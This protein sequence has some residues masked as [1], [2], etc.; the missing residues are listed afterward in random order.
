MATSLV[1]D[2]PYVQGVSAKNELGFRA[3]G[4]IQ[5]EQQGLTEVS[6]V[7]WYADKL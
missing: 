1:P 2:E 6:Q 4:V 3:L 7:Y 5:A